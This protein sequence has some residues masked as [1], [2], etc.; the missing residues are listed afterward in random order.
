MRRENLSLDDA[1]QSLTPAPLDD[2]EVV[3]KEITA[4]DLALMLG[5]TGG[6]Q[7]LEGGIRHGVSL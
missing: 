1:L 3:H 6:E 5:V 7:E 4:V 2:F